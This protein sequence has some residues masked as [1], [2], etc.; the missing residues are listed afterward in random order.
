MRS[1]SNIKE[2]VAQRD[3]LLE[4]YDKLKTLEIVSAESF[5][6]IDQLKLNLCNE[7][8]IISVCGQMNA[9]K[10][11]L[12]NA[13]LFG[14]EVL[15]CDDTAMTAQLT[16]IRHGDTPGFEVVFCDEEQWKQIRASYAQSPELKDDF[17]AAIAY[18]QDQHGVYEGEVI[19]TPAQRKKVSDIATL[20]EYVAVPKK[21]G[22]YAP[23]VERVIL[24]FND[25]LLKDVV[26]VDTPG[27]NDPNPVRSRVTEDWIGKSDAVIYVA[28]AGQA[29]DAVD[30]EFIDQYLLGVQKSRIVVAVNKVDTV[31]SRS[32]LEGWLTKLRK[33][34]SGGERGVFSGEESIVYT[35]SLA[36]LILRLQKDDKPLSPSLAEYEERLD[37]KDMLNEESAGIARLRE[38]VEKRLIENKGENLLASHARSIK[39]VFDRRERELTLEQEE[40][41]A[42]ADILGKDIEKLKEEEARL[43][44]Q[45]SK[46]SE[47]T[48]QCTKDWN[49]TKVPVLRDLDESIKSIKNKAFDKVK[50]S[51]SEVNRI[52]SFGT[53]AAWAVK[54][55]L[56]NSE[57]DILD[58]LTST[59]R[60]LEEK[61]DTLLKEIKV[62]MANELKLTVTHI[63]T[64]L[65]TSSCDALE[66]LAALA[67]R[68]NY[69]ESMQVQIK[70]NTRFWQRWF[71]TAV[72]R[73]D[74]RNAVKNEARNVI[75]DALSRAFRDE[76][77][78]RVNAETDAVISNIEEKAQ[79]ILQQKKDEVD[80]V[81]SDEAA[82]TERYE[83]ARKRVAE[84][85]G[86]L[87]EVQKMKTEVL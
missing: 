49:R 39:S 37:G 45:L 57:A 82:K 79:C 69:D 42:K 21:G 22:R 7:Q 5:A 26:I 41:Q 48:K 16:E 25:P 29:M 74:A 2:F 19:S 63:D 60:E 76:V 59:S 56:E 64:L 46:A 55:A 62:Y 70:N 81:L 72:G 27:I 15:P 9:G 31:S 87:E 58:A 65:E 78:T 35:S 47:Y 44:E 73:E 18:C 36:G 1:I 75:E 8:F 34:G 67:D 28:Y 14:D 77:K 4:K 33:S 61:L 50:C 32:D 17:D 40:E 23:F 13:W 30:A 66:T 71:N 51:L 12:L 80:Y 6:D 84:I 83:G 68:R 3:A 43:K 10:S 24:T 53:E 52:N 86:M 38:V 85:K 20:H 11:T 54:A